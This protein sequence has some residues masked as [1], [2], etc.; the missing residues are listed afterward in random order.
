MSNS[1]PQNTGELDLRELR[2]VAHRFRWACELVQA[3]GLTKFAGPFPAGCCGD[4]S[5]ILGQYLYDEGYGVFTYVWGTKH[6]N[7]TG[8]RSHAWLQRENVIVDI[9]ADQFA[10][11][12]SKVL[13]ATHS[14]WHQKWSV[15]P[16]SHD[17][18]F[19]C[20][21]QQRLKEL[22][23]AVR[24]ELTQFVQL[25]NTGDGRDYVF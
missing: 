13:V 15:N 20:W 1:S 25:E 12:K 21:P 6:S 4:A 11:V 18:L 24:H 5:M 9:T 3:N 2:K 7:A 16:A 23:D 17:A 19:S 8:Y 14:V 22:L 10:R